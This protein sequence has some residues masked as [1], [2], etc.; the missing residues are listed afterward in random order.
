MKTKQVIHLKKNDVVVLTNQ[1]SGKRSEF[2]VQGIEIDEE[3]PALPIRVYLLIPEP[4]DKNSTAV[5]GYRWR[6][7]VEVV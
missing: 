1:T 2:K 7:N 6:D 5:V 4:F 3:Y